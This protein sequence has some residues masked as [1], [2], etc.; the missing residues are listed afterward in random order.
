MLTLT[1]SGR[2]TRNQRCARRCRARRSPR[3][4]IAGTRRG[5][6][7][8]SIYVD[9]VLWDAQAEFAVEHVVKGQVV[10][11]AGVAGAA[12]VD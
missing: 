1:G 9:L 6:D 5:S 8:D 2:L 11:F 3:W 4:R 7:V 10:T 12:T